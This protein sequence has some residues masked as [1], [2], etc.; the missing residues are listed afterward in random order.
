MEHSPSQVSAPEVCFTDFRVCRAPFMDATCSPAVQD[1]AGC[2]P[3]S[4]VSLTTPPMFVFLLFMPASPSPSE[5]R[6]LLMLTAPAN[7]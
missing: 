1:R 2:G 5:M 3:S 7:D 6:L 4:T